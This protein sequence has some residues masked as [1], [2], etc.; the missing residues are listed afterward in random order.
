MK[1]K[2]DVERLFVYLNPKFDKKFFEECNMAMDCF[3]EESFDD[4]ELSRFLYY[5]LDKVSDDCY[6]EAKLKIEEFLR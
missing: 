3:I 5:L 2:K 1:T 4:G 6:E